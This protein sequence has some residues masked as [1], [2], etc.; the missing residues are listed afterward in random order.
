VVPPPPVDE[1]RSQKPLHPFSTAA[2]TTN[3]AI[4]TP[5]A[6]QYLLFI[7]TPRALPFESQFVQTELQKKIL[8]KGYCLIARFVLSPDS[9]R[10]NGAAPSA[11]VSE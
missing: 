7:F 11:M 2:T 10:V 1:G 3:A 4:T 8:L 9:T 5:S 6:A